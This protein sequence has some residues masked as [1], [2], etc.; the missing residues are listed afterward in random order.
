M[1]TK[2][3]RTEDRQPRAG[4]R[5][6][7]S[8]SKLPASQ[9]VVVEVTAKGKTRLMTVSHNTGRPRVYTVAKEVN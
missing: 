1:P 3:G 6:I 7:P 5:V 4:D 2:K 9:R 8:R